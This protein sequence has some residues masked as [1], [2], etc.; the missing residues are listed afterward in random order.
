M[1]SGEFPNCLLL[2]SQ[3]P[4]FIFIFVPQKC[5]Q[6]VFNFSKTVNFLWIFSVFLK[7]GKCFHKLVC[8]SWWSCSFELC[9][10]PLVGLFWLWN[11][12]LSRKKERNFHFVLLQRKNSWE[13]SRQFISIFFVSR[14]KSTFSRFK[15]DGQAIWKFWKLFPSLKTH[16]RQWILILT[17][18][19]AGNLVNPKRTF[20]RDK[21]NTAFWRIPFSLS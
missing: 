5:K 1:R 11:W 19:F 18:L 16:E 12:I 20:R 17:K 4:I 3:V 21:K 9:S 8:F 10:F 15:E 14:L 13:L 6:F 7:V 2:P